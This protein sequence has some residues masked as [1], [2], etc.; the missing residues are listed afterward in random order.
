MYDKL[1]FLM[2]LLCS[3]TSFSQNDKTIIDE[4]ESI[5]SIEKIGRGER[6]FLIK[7]VNVIDSSSIYSDLINNNIQHIN[8]LLTHYSDLTKNK[9]LL[10]ITDSV[11]LQ[12]T[13]IE[14]LK[15]DSTFKQVISELS[16]STFQK[17][18]I[19]DTISMD[20]IL[21]ISVKYFS[22]IK[23]TEEGYYLGKVCTGVNGISQTREIRKPHPEAFCFA[24]IITNYEGEKYNMY[25]EFVAGI[26]ELYK[27]NLGINE[28]EKLLRAQGAMYMFMRSNKNLKE[29]IRSEYLKK[30]NYLPFII[31]D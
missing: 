30:K 23:I 11:K 22:I 13:F 8:F 24:A 20:E 7:N 15:S 18:F 5:F 6:S 27:L 17:D 1:I 9:E 4:F 26:K 2:L 14:N 10:A 25:N 19:P 28:E 21:D 12:T 16:E 3:L 29:M 31:L